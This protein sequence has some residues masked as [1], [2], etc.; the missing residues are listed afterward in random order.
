[1]VSPMCKDF[2]STPPFLFLLLYTP[3]FVNKTEKIGEKE[4]YIDLKER[5]EM[6][7][8]AIIIHILIA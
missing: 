7:T 4:L 1:M 3:A 5:G 8:Y 6:L 2:H